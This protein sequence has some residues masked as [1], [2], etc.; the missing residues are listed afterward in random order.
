MNSQDLALKTYGAGRLADAFNS[1]APIAPVIEK[2]ARQMLAGV[3]APLVGQ[4]EASLKIFT[5]FTK[6][7]IRFETEDGETFDAVE[8]LIDFQVEANKRERDGE[9]LSKYL[10]II[11]LALERLRA[12]LPKGTTI[13]LPAT[14]SVVTQSTPIPV[15]VVSLPERVTATQIERDASGAIT[16]STQIERDKVP[17]C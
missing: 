3:S 12:V 2:S 8:L 14:E 5:A 7:G 16:A 9:K 6:R 1:G 4:L 15:Q 17:S 10:T 13:T 11:V